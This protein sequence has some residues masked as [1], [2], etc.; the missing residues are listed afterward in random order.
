MYITTSR[1]PSDPTRRLAR[2]ISNFI[3]VYENRGKKSVHDVVKRAGE[4]NETHILMISDKSGNP[5]SLSF[6]AIE[7]GEEWKW[8]DPEVVIN[9]KEPLP[10]SRKIQKP[11][12]YAGEIKYSNLF[13][14]QEPDTDDFVVLEM[15]DKMLS[16]TYKKSKFTLNIIG[17]RRLKVVEN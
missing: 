4:L 10:V 9:F 13:G 3:G 15:N 7:D 8:V 14:L 1:K 5:E 16:F 11:V 12:K 17:F 6:I 2:L